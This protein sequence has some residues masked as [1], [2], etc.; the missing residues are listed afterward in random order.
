MFNTKL[1]FREWYDL[2]FVQRSFDISLKHDFISFRKN[3]DNTIHFRR[4]RTKLTFY[5]FFYHAKDDT[6][7]ITEHQTFKQT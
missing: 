4:I 1:T 3:H 2:S 6:Y 5:V 7:R